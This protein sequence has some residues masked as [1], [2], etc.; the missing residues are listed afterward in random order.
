MRP[1]SGQPGCPAVARSD[2]PR[3]GLA[4]RT[5]AGRGHRRVGIEC[6]SRVCRCKRTWPKPPGPSP[7]RAS[8]ATSSRGSLA[9]PNPGC[10]RVERLGDHGR[11]V[12]GETVGVDLIPQPGGESVC[13]LLAVVRGTVESPINPTH[14]PTTQ[15][16]E[17]GGE[18]QG[19][20]GDKE[21][22][23]LADHTG[24]KP[25]RPKAVYECQGAGHQRIGDGAT[26]E[27]VDLEQSVAEDG[28]CDGA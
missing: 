27:T 14:D 16:T 23:L 8:A 9:Y 7:R 21:R 25:D 17:E 18:G 24:G 3:P 5:R 19:G 2:T 20:G 10:R 12:L 22:G 1:E 28:Q 6:R 4:R 15:R 11:P 26:D 13:D